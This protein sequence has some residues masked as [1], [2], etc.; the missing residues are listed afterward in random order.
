MFLLFL[1][2]FWLL[3]FIVKLYSRMNVFKIKVCITSN[4][5][6]HHSIKQ[7]EKSL[8]CCQKFYFY[9][10]LLYKPPSKILKGLIIPKVSLQT[11]SKTF[12]P[13]PCPCE[14]LRI[15]NS[16]LCHRISKGK[17]VKREAPLRK[18]KEIQ[19]I[20]SLKAKY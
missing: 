1:N 6:P 2:S 14:E 7:P 9:R 12:K 19:L 17:I 16:R 5:V 20:M 18:R 8:K 13:I 10:N 11:Y 15:P 3:F 4:N